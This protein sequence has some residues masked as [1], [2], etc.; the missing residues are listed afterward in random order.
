MAPNSNIKIEKR[1]D[2]ANLQHKKCRWTADEV[3]LLMKLN[4]DLN[5][6]IEMI[7]NYFPKRTT[8]SITKKMKEIK[9]IKEKK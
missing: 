4:K 8:E 7:I 5:G 2:A 3:D 6:K 1:Q 9:N